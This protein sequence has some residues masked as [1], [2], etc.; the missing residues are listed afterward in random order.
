MSISKLD[1]FFADR[2]VKPTFDAKRNGWYMQSKSNEHVMYVVRWSFV[3]NEGDF[4]C[5]NR[6]MER[7]TVEIA[8]CDSSREAQA[9]REAAPRYSEESEAW[10][11]IESH[12]VGN[13]YGTAEAASKAR[14]FITENKLRNKLKELASK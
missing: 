5:S 8:M 3:A 11:I 7:I 2:K 4:F 6:S 1:K 13:A 14:K 12:H 10:K 9:I